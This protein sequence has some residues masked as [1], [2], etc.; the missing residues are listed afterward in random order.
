MGSRKVY[1]NGMV[2]M[3]DSRRRFIFHFVLFENIGERGRK[4]NKER[5]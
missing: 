2:K 1:S 5:M 4:K 3:L